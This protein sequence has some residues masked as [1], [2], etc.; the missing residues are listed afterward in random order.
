VT[1][2][3][4]LQEVGEK[5][6]ASANGKDGPKAVQAILDQAL[7]GLM[8]EPTPTELELALRNL[9]AEITG[10]DS[11]TRQLVRTSAVIELEELKVRGAAGLVDAALKEPQANGA[12]ELAGQSIALEDPSPA[13]EP[14]DGVVLV[15]EI[16]ERIRDHVILGIAPAIM[17]ALWVVFTYVHDAFGVSPILGFVSPSKR[18]GKTTALLLASALVRR[19][20]PASNVTSAALFRAIDQYSPTLLIDEAD[21]FLGFREELRGILNAGHT[22]ATATVVRTV[23]DDHEA[24]LFST[25]APK[26][27]ALI[28]RPPDTL[29]D[30][31]VI[32]TLHRKTPAE[33]VTPLR[34][35][36][37][38]RELE[39]LRRRA[40]RWARD[41]IDTLRV[42]DPEVPTEL[43]D[44]AAGN[45]RPLLA[46]ADAAGG[47]WPSEARDAA[48]TLSGSLEGDSGVEGLLLA[49]LQAMFTEHKVQQLPSA[50][51]CQA[52]AELEHRPWPEWG[53]T[54]APITPRG[55][56]RLLGRFGIKP[57]HWRDG[58]ETVRGYRRKDFE[59]AWSRYLSGTSGTSGTAKPSNDLPVPD[60]PA[61]PDGG[62]VE[63]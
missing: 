40:A 51:I 8:E 61:V 22:R 48:R 27:V 47:V 45:W 52:L 17:M 23:G 60:V 5:Q 33:T 62:T 58:K 16:Y 35:D 30:R 55:L 32:I 14:V 31:T 24:R 2:P 6:N 11:I 56:A 41:H 1:S 37:L 49:D 63:A 28:G 50:A 21:T 12:R 59:D 44:R 39:G 38:Y 15:D 19:P 34:L 13:A 46:I 42:S 54:G 43:N 18:C 57:D 53:R 29:E 26:A 3:E 4:V 20:L 9:R 36:R 10:T 7:G 25:Y